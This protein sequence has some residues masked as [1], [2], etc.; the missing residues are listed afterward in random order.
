VAGPL[1]CLGG[2]IAFISATISGTD[3]YY[4][5]SESGSGTGIWLNAGIQFDVNDDF[6]LGAEIRSSSADVTLFNTTVDA[7]GR[8]IGLLAGISF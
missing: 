4:S 6:Y 5:A 8:H 3:G 1:A 7:G 2:G